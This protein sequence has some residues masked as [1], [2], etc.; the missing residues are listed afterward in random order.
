MIT[1]ARSKRDKAPPYTLDG[2]I[3]DILVYEI[4]PSGAG[5]NFDLFMHNIAGKTAML[6]LLPPPAYLYEVDSWETGK[7]MAQEHFAVV[8]AMLGLTMKEKTDD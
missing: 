6:G 3:N 1:W 2:M 4:R 8:T 5:E 7:E